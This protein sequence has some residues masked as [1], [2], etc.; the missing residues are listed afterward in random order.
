MLAL[1][2]R[3]YSGTPIGEVAYSVSDSVFEW[4]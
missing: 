4:L 2:S 3:T 1:F